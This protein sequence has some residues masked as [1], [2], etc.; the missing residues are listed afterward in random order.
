M[1]ATH[2]VLVDQNLREKLKVRGY[3]QAKRFSWDSSVRRILKVYE[4][5]GGGRSAKDTKEAKSSVQVGA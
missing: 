4:E 5:V 1:R 2:C 3:E